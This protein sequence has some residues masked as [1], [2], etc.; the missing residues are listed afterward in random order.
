M[1]N[2]DSKGHVTGKSIYLDDIPLIQGTCFGI[3]FDSPVA[4]GTITSVD[5]SKAFAYPGVI[6]IITHKS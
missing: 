5:Y 4:H 6:K 3:V 2:I 1:K